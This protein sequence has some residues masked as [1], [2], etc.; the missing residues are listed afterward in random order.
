[1]TEPS[2]T[3]VGP[4]ADETN[5]TVTEAL[6]GP[7]VGSRTES[8]FG[9]A[10][11]E[12]GALDRAVYQTVGTTPTNHLDAPF[13]NLSRAAD[14]SLLW[15]AIAGGVAATRGP[16]GRRVA[17][18]S[19]ASLA[20]TAVVVNLGAKSVFRRRRPDRTVHDR[21]EAGRVPSPSS[22]SF[23]SGHSATCSAFAYT[24]GRHLPFLGLPIRLLAAGVAYSRVH[25][26][27][28]Y[29]GDVIV[30]SVMG[31]GTAAAVGT[32]WDRRRS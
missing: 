9:A 15:L 12:F 25:I 29:P 13:R 20:V 14:A 16:R 19:I 27:V 31:A 6:A 28:H 22:T 24:I 3:P 5:R 1:M 7:A 8:P 21:T 17:A 4:P 2:P 11:M 23:P 32:W 18:E 30:G 10:L 26:G